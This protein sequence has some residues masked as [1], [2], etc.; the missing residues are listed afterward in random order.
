MCLASAPALLLWG[1]II[2]HTG[3]IFL[4]ELIAFIRTR[5]SQVL[6]YSIGKFVSDIRRLWTR[7]L[8]SVDQHPN[9]YYAA[10]SFMNW[11]SLGIY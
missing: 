11:Q 7:V 3:Q 4:V 8:I 10:R 6:I 2:R 1:I 9:S 5:P